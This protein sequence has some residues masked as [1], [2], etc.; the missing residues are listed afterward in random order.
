MPSR[1][2]VEERILRV[3]R[4]RA[5]E[6]DETFF[7]AL[8]DKLVSRYVETIAGRE[9]GERERARELRDERPAAAYSREVAQMLYGC[10]LLVATS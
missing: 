10:E 4:E 1:R 8:G 5:H 9:L 7:R 2:V 3:A 6:L